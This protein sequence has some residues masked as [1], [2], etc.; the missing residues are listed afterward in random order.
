MAW[1]WAAR[2]DSRLRGNDLRVE[3]DTV[4]Y[5][6]TS[7]GAGIMALSLGLSMFQIFC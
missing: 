3:R 6:A 7:E 5:D 4:R 1:G 2:L